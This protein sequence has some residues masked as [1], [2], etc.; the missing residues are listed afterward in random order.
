[1]INKKMK[2][3]VSSTMLVTLCM[4]S[5][6]GCG[7]KE[8]VSEATPSATPE[9]T[10]QA[11]ATPEATPEEPA[12]DLGG[13]EIIIGDWWSSGEETAPTTAEEEATQEYRKMIQEK[14]NFTI[15]QVGLTGWGEYQENFTV[16]VMAEEPAAQVF[17]MAPSF[18]AQPMA[19]GLFYDLA[20]LDSIDVK[21]DKWNQTI[22][23]LMSKGDSVY[24]LSKGRVEPR[25]GVFWNKRLF[26]EAGLD[27]DLP[28][29]LQ[30]S[31]EWTWD[32]F[33]ELC[34]TLTKD[35]DN[36]GVNDTHA[37][38]NF[39]VEYFQ[40]ATLSNNAMWIDK[41]ADGKYV[42]KTS[43]PEFLEAMQW[44]VGLIEKGYEMPTPADAEWDW[45]IAAFHDAKVA[46]TVAE[47]YKTGTWKDMED[48]F[49]FVMFPKGPKATDYATNVIEN[50]A[51]I[52]S[53]YDKET[54]EKI[55]FAYNLWTEPTPGYEADDDWKNSYYAQFRD[56]RAVDE[57][58]ELVY[59]P[60]VGHVDYL[61]LIYGMSYGDIAYNV[62]GL[63]QT[64]A[65]KI[66]EVSGTWE[67]LLADANK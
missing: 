67:A 11:E 43:S 12:R 41:D 9:A 24:G 35:K 15:K 37:M 57:T 34:A 33:A 38:A 58:L 47:Q 56:E 36:D 45:F 17:I 30:A 65:E 52:P 27:P 22:V 46:M 40:A 1:M 20:T 32:K 39:S 19:N 6:I 44:A 53:C 63:N 66:E 2:K 10:V 7:P 51:V 16:S 48:D 18:V 3:Y 29:D 31:G 26:Q 28:Y 4:S 21:S 49:G 62:Y 55:A 59:K 64:P 25:L 23:N 14:Y 42:N 54:A 5:L 60:G 8:T 61:S 50:V 13:M